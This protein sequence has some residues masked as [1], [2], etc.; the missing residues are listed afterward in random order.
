MTRDS[1]KT[2]AGAALNVKQEKRKKSNILPNGLVEGDEEEEHDG[3]DGPELQR[4]GRWVGQTFVRKVMHGRFFLLA[5]ASFTLFGLLSF[6]YDIITICIQN[7]R[8]IFQFTSSNVLFVSELLLKQI[9][10]GV[11]L[12]AKLDTSQNLV[13]FCHQCSL[14]T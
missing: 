11:V 13:S 6:F 10:V 14:I 8:G 3:H 2:T 9:H 5:E 12:S 1:T 4:T 7:E